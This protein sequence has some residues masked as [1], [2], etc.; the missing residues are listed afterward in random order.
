MKKNNLEKTEEN[1]KENIVKASR[2]EIEQQLNPFIGNIKVEGMSGDGKVALVYFK[3]ELGKLSRE[4]DEFR[5]TTI[6][7]IDKPKNYDDLKVKSEVKDATEEDKQAYKE[8]EAEYNKAF[9]EIALPYFN[10]V[11]EIP[12]EYIS[13]DDFKVLIKNN[14]LKVI[15]GYEYIYEKLVKK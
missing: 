9:N 15:F 10:E 8:V 14:D 4:I 6:A 11:I 13:E 2:F 7:S 5:K 3:I 1:N 12:F